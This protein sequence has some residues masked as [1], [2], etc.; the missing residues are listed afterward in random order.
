MFFSFSF[1]PSVFAAR[2]K[3]LRISHN[4]TMDALAKEIHATKATI[5]NFENVNKKPSLDAILALADY[6][7]VSVDYLLGRPDNPDVNQ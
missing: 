5:G 6:F 3:A 2:I 1:E 7:N 4:L